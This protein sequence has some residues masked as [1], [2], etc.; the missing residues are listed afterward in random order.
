MSGAKSTQGADMSRL[1]YFYIAVMFFAF[2][3]QLYWHGCM[4]GIRFY[5]Q[6]KSFELALQS[7][8]NFGLVDGRVHK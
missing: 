7:M 4:D 2:G 5:K 8:Y 1:I 3:T 6:S